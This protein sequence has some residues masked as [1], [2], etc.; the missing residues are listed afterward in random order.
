MLEPLHVYGHGKLLISGEYLIMKGAKG[1]AVPVRFKQHLRVKP[2]AE[3]LVRWTSR[4]PDKSVWMQ[5][6]YDL[7]LN[8]I[9]GTP[10]N[11]AGLIRNILSVLK[12]MNPNLF[13][14]GY[15]LETRTEFSREW[16]M[17][18]SSSLIAVLSKWA[19]VNPFELLDRT[20]GGSGFDVAV[21]LGGKQMLFWREKN[22]R[23][24]EF[25]RWQPPFRKRIFFV[26]LN[27]KQNTARVVKKFAA[28]AVN[29]ETIE[30][31]TQITH[32]MLE[33]G[34]MSRFQEL[35][36]EHEH[37]VG[38]LI[39]KRPVATRLFPDYDGAIKSLGAWGG[40]MIM[41]VGGS[42]PETYFRSKG[43]ELIFPFSKLIF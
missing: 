28:T 32:Q 41:A 30:R 34:D 7:D 19:Q 17:G 6:E 39:G 15:T 25:V 23:K 1:L 10:A 5:A 42:N 2:Q 9:A 20:F 43:F 40:D 3:P 8:M 24:W 14:R 13:R 38:K 4:H 36:A 33:T 26:H 35:M 27:R 16:G 12:K 21:S 11:D 29:P 22:R 37:I 18:T 31:I